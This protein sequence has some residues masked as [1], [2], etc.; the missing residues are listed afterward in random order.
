[1]GSTSPQFWHRRRVFVTG[2]TGFLGTWVVRELLAAGAEVA[3][4]VRARVADSDLFRDRLFERIAVVRGRVEDQGRLE[5]SLALHDIQT[6]FHLASPGAESVLAAAL[7]AVPFG[8]VTLPV[9]IGDPGRAS[10][11]SAFARR[12]GYRVGLAELPALFGGGSQTV[13]RAEES[14]LYVRDAARALLTLA[15]AVVADPMAWSGWPIR[16]NP[17]TTGR[18]L[19]AA[20]D[21][22]PL[23]APSATPLLTSHPLGW[24]PSVSLADA[25]AETIAWPRGG[26]NRSPQRVT[27]C[28]A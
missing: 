20:L 25:V 1:M 9:P 7:R 15:E 12:T 13:P 10:L 24:S 21:R 16:F 11:V 6:V 28:A 26:R 22:Q 27:V 14:Y 8:S 5:T 17:T 19:S 4:L 2:C 3:G 23:D 18:E